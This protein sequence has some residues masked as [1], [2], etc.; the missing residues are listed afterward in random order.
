MSRLMPAEFAEWA[1]KHAL[2]FGML[3]QEEKQMVQGWQP[4]F[5]SMGYTIEDLRYTTQ[6]MARNPPKYRTDHLRGIHAIIGRVRNAAADKDCATWD[7]IDS[8]ETCKHCGGCGLVPVPHLRYVVNGE[9]VL[10]QRAGFKPDCVVTCSCNMGQ[11]IA[12]THSGTKR[13][14][15]LGQYEERNPKWEQHM[16]EHRA[17]RI[18]ERASHKHAAALDRS[19]GQLASDLAANMACDKPDDEAAIATLKSRVST[20][21]QRRLYDDNQPGV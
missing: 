11:R 20:Q 18:A 1:V 2:T 19:L 9:W 3:S 21:R 6:E 4:C 5:L 17:A 14:M 13:P 15:S 10:Y 7:A 8:F 12:G 16:A